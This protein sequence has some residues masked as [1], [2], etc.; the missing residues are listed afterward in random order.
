M[1]IVTVLL[2]AC[3]NP[4]DISDAEYAKYKELAAPKILYACHAA[5]RPDTISC[6][7]LLPDAKKHL[8]CL[9]DVMKNSKGEVSVGYSA[10]VGFAVTYN[11]LL[12]D[13]QASCDGRL[14]VLKSES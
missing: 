8:S 12:A 3:G 2:V 6:N 10:G 4:G 7:K 11:K 14:E 1:L 13:A 5:P 9:E